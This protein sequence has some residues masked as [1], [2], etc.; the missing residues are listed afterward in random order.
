M[1]KWMKEN[2]MGGIYKMQQAFTRKHD[3]K[4]LMTESQ[5]H[6]LGDL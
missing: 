3:M 1:L 6:V 5:R 4:N 2:K